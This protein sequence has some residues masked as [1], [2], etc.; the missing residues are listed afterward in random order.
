M[1]KE[2]A[3][4]DTIFPRRTGLKFLPGCLDIITHQISKV[5]RIPRHVVKNE[6][7]YPDEDT[8]PPK[9]TYIASPT[10]LNFMRIFLKSYVPS[11]SGVEAAGRAGGARGA[12]G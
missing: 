9:A 8:P 7:S 1:Q 3:S 10:G 2:N 12:G 4:G 11:G 5:L 6:P